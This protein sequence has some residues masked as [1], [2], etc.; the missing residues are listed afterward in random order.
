MAQQ[1][2]IIGLGHFGMSLAK[3]LSDKGAEVL[4]V[5]K[6]KNL[7][8]EASVFVTEALVMDATDEA[9]LAKLEPKKRDS[10]V[11]TI[12]EGAKDASIICT[13]MLRQMGVPLVISRASDKMH[14]RILTLVGAHQ[15]IDPEQEFSDRFANKLLFKNIIVDSS[16]GEDLHLTEMCI[17]PSMVGKSM[18]ELEL[19]KKYGVMVIGVRRGETGRIHKPEPGEKLMKDDILILVSTESAI[20]KLI[21][22]HE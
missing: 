3:N 9:E 1:V 17:M 11:C 18:I 19:P 8:E 6:K 21:K 10:A 5:D 12:G 20:P 15:V 2:L 13:A 22:G 7:V 16:V 4:A 14:R